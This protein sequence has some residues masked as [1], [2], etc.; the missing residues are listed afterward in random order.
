MSTGRLMARHI[1]PNVMSSI[2]VIATLEVGTMILGEGALS[3]LALGVT[4][5]NVSWGLMLAEGRDYLRQAWWIVVFPGLAITV[6]VLLSNLAGDAL[7]SRYD[8]RLRTHRP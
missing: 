6:V 7:R 4:E 1:V 8:P 5:P 3:F 2:V